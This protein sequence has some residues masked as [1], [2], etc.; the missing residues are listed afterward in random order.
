M[1][2]VLVV[3]DD[4]R[5]AKV[6]A[7]YVARVP[8]F[9]VT[10]QAHSAAEALATIESR[11]VDLVLLDH[12]MPDR[13][14]LAMVRELRRRGHHTDVIMV[15]AARDVATVQEAMRHGALQYLVKPFAYAGLR[16]KLEAYAA[17]RHTLERGGEAEQGEVDR[18]FGALWA[19]GEPDLPKGHSPT[20]AELVRQ[21][22]RSAEGPLSAQEIAESAGMSRQT[23]Q[24]YL[25]LLER[26]GRVRLTLR[27]GETGRPE[28]R[29]TWSTGTQT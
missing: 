4:I 5:V 22:L 13:N 1:I 9:R 23:A 19:A 7:A 21:A 25:K 2:E 16:T 20:T 11:P 17:L 14:G 8:G 10:A 26:T 3:D 6:N 24:R 18:L 28:H 27:Y 15:T 29:Y 12:Y